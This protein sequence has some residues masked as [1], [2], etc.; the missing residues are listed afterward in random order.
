MSRLELQEEEDDESFFEDEETEEDCELWSPE[1][2]SEPRRLLSHT[3]TSGN[4]RRV[5]MAV[6]S[7]E[8]LAL[9]CT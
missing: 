8:L 7:C 2:P 5:Y 9:S 6:A 1:F 3:P 4:H